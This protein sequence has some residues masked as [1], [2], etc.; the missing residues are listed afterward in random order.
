MYIYIYICIY[1]YIRGSPRSPGS[2]RRSAQACPPAGDVHTLNHEEALCMC[3]RV[4]SKET[5]QP[6]PTPPREARR[7][8]SKHGSSRIH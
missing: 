3:S 1:T 4:F 7:G 2:R 8:C 5:F 6:D